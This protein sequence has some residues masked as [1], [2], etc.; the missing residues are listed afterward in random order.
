MKS[1]ESKS[2]GGSSYIQKRVQ[3]GPAKRPESKGK[4][5]YD[6]AKFMNNL[7]SGSAQVEKESDLQ[8]D[9]AELVEETRP[10]ESPHN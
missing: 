5:T 7:E 8:I 6:F 3:P 10:L 9:V 4:P 2:R 1:S